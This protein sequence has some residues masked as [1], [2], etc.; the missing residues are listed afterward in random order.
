MKSIS[1]PPRGHFDWFDKLTAGRLRAGSG[2]ED[3]KKACSKKLQNVT[4]L[5]IECFVSGW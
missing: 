2:G 4:V 1:S 3:A 5:E